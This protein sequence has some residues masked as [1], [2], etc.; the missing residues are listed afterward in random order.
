MNLSGVF[1]LSNQISQPVSAL[2]PW[3]QEAKEKKAIMDDPRLVEALGNAVV[4]DIRKVD[5]GYLVVTDDCEMR[6]DVKYLPP[7]SHIC[8]PAKFELVFHPPIPFA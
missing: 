2:P 6:V 4:K 7:E 1:K 8:G 3:V 5:G